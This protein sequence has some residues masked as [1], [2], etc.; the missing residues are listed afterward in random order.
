MNGQRFGHAATLLINGK[1]LI[2]G[3]TA[4]SAPV[5]TAE[6][7]DPSSATFSSLP[8]MNSARVYHS[9]T[10][11][12]DGKVL[13]AGGRNNA[14][15]NATNTAE[16]FDPS[17]GAFISLPNMTVAREIPRA[18]L[19]A[20]GKV[21]ITGGTQGLDTNK[22]E[23]FDPAS[24]SFSALPTMNSPRSGHTSTL[25]P[26]G[27]VLLAG[28]YNNNGNYLNTAE[29]FDPASNTFTSI[30]PMNSMRRFHKASLLA[31]GKVLLTGGFVST[32][33]ATNTAE[34][35]DPLFGTFAS[36]SPA[37]M[38]SAR[39][40]QTSTL[41]P[42][43]RVLIAGGDTGSVATA[44]ADLFAI[45]LGF[46]DARR[47][48]ISGVPAFIN[49]P[50]PVLLSGSGFL[51]DSEASG[52]ATNNS[53]TNYPLLQLM[54]FD[55]EQVVTP[56]SDPTM[57]WSDTTFTSVTLGAGTP[58]PIGH[59]RLTIFTNGI[60]SF[61]KGFK[62]TNPVQLLSALSRKTHTGVGPFDINL[63]LTGNSG[64]ECRSG[65]ASNDYQ[66]VFAFPSAVTFNSAA[67]TAGAGA[68]S[69]SSGSGTT[70]VTVNLTGVTNAQN[71]TVTLLGVNNGTSIGD[72]SVQMGVLVGDT[73]AD[74]FVNAGDSLQTRNRSGQATDA[75]NFR[76][77]VNA[78]GFIN[79]GDTTVVRARSG[80]FLP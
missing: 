31:N 12:A 37:T 2:T 49:Q 60:P 67:V 39:E 78:D 9:M 50:A 43:G 5:N 75:T 35:F 15:G 73:N 58:L 21:L 28:G 3:G 25:L 26:N 10:L 34:L 16:L 71:I 42:S 4:T 38:G 7:F 63:P 54:R 48:I 47:P 32:G 13:I 52:G 79:S 46:S 70:T 44:T 64:V 17:S 61:E 36:L 40:G 11:L 72:V 59:Y 57:P 18:T 77:D 29:L 24:A 65:G 45:G 8:N 53:A 14:G 74:R 27:K 33:T 20:N 66:V 22:A 68:V 23:L 76:S 80:T 41:L 55:N 62:I 19:L 56:L 1:V 51:G 30:S 69:G 6:L